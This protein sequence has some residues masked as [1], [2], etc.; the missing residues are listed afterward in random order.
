M[1]SGS[2]Y[3]IDLLVLRTLRAQ[4]LVLALG[5]VIL[6]ATAIGFATLQRLGAVL[7]RDGSRLVSMTAETRQTMLI[8]ALK[9]HQERARGLLSRL[10]LVCKS[11]NKIDKKCV[12]NLFQNFVASDLARSAVLKYKNLQSIVS[13]N[14]KLSLL[15]Q[16]SGANSLATFRFD[17]RGQSYYVIQVKTDDAELTVSYNFTTLKKIFK[18]PPELGEQ[19]E[20]FLINSQG[21]FITPEQFEETHNANLSQATRECLSGKSGSMIALDYHGVPAI[22]A[23]RYVPE[24]GGGCIKAF[25][26][27]SQLLAPLSTMKLEVFSLILIFLLL[28]ALLAYFLSNRVLSPINVLAKR[29]YALEAGDMDSP[30]PVQGPF[31]IQQFARTFASM[32]AA[33]NKM[34]RDQEEFLAIVSHDLKNPIANIKLCAGFIEKLLTSEQGITESKVKILDRARKVLSSCQQMQNLITDLL[35]SAKM[36][37]GNLSIERKPEDAHS[38]IQE[39]AK[40]FQDL[41]LEKSISLDIEASPG[42]VLVACDRA[43]I[44][45]VM[46]NLIGNA[47]KFTPEGGH[48]S[49]GF[50]SSDKEAIFFVKDTGPGISPEAMQY[51]FDRFWQAKHSEK[52][53][54]GLGLYICRHIILAHGGRIWAESALGQGVTFRFSILRFPI[55]GR[56]PLENGEKL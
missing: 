42:Q 8:R 12:L 23:F 1:E 10:N 32:A 21:E 44:F 4:I 24:I 16:P 25:V 27:E 13:W 30:V 53:G 56:N 54:H 3:G 29:V 19:G 26:P 52:K 6:T 2:Q 41:A 40:C 15:E 49:I 45:Q 38:I 46:S 51:L 47:L 31:E 39:A 5:V 36:E 43:R 33:L 50:N 7:Q 35:D 17:D 34:I 14:R 22:H 48:I 55:L 18:Q 37:A 20:T 11:T 28:A 9:G